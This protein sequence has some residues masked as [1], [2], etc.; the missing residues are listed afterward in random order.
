MGE[1]ERGWLIIEDLGP[2]IWYGLRRW[3][4]NK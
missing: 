1:T 2:G 3:Y 4:E